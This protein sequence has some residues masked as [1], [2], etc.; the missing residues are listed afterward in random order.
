VLENKELETT[1][2]GTKKNFSLQSPVVSLSDRI[3]NTMLQ[4]LDALSSLYQIITGKFSF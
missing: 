4:S 3:S 2:K 1:K